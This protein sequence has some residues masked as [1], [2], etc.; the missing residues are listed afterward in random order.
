MTDDPK[1][2]APDQ[3]PSKPEEAAPAAEPN[4]AAAKPAEVAPAQPDTPA[5]PAPAPAPPAA[6]AA[7]AKPKPAPKAPPE[8]PK[9]PSDP[10]PPDDVAEPAF[11][12]SLRAAH[13]DAI[14]QV[15]YWVGDWTVIIEASALLDVARTLRDAPDAAFDYCSDVTATDWPPRA[16]RFDVIYCLYSTRLR[17]RIRVKVQADSTEAVPSV[18]GLW[19]AANWLE[20][21]VYDMFGVNIVGHPDRRRLLM[22]DEWQGY[23]QRKDYPLEG[24]GELLMENPEE[25]L[26]LRNLRDEAEIE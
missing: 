12:A 24:P 3:P 21:E 14:R 2:G 19:P 16:K 26:R 10:S 18:T 6:A 22:P 4:E 9:G 5:P 11:L 23:P 20:R 25:W 13:G 8:A 15:S 1:P 7:P 17:H